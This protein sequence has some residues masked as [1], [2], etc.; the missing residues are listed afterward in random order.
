M[1]ATGWSP[2][3]ESLQKNTARLSTLCEAIELSRGLKAAAHQSLLQ[4]NL[5]R[6]KRLP[7]T[8]P[9]SWRIWET[10]V[11][12]QQISRMLDYLLNDCDLD[13]EEE[14]TDFERE[15][16]NDIGEME[17]NTKLSDMQIAKLKEIYDAH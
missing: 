16:V 9:T 4:R 15:F 3:R 7:L 11:D 2:T 13:D 8:S 6:R 10:D 5:R 14:F 12:N 17:E 1:S